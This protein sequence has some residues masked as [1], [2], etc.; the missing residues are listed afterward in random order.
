MSTAPDTTTPTVPV[1]AP[2]HPP[3]KLLGRADA[4]GCCGGGSCGV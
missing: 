2:A 3:I 1:E 4:G